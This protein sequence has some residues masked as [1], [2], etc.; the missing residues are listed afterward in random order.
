MKESLSTGRETGHITIVEKVKRF[1]E[2]QKT[3]EKIGLL[4]NK[5]CVDYGQFCFTYRTF[6]RI[7]EE[8]AER[9]LIIIEKVIGP[10]GNTTI[11]KKLDE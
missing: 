3:E 8:L 7:I 9:E 11:V 10:T 6:Q 2:E 1:I 4:Y 5:Y